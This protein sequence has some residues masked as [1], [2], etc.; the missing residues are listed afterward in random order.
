LRGGTSGK[1]PRFRHDSDVRY[2][3]YGSRVLRRPF[4]ARHDKNT[5]KDDTMHSGPA[6]GPGSLISENTRI[7]ELVSQDPLYAVYSAES[8]ASGEKVGITE[9]F[10]GDLVARAPGGDVLLRSLELQNLFNL[11]RDRFMAEARALS[12]LRH[13]G[14]LRFDGV[15]S[16]HGT[17]FALHAAEEGQSVTSLIKSSKQPLPQEAMDAIVKQLASALELMHSRNLIHANITPDTILLR[18]DPLLVRFGATRSFIAARM[19]K[20]NLAVTPG[21]SAPELHFSDEKARGPL[22]DIFSLAAVL[23]F[24]VTGR[25]PVNVIARGLGQTMPPAAGMPSHKFRP[26]FLEAIDRGLELEPERRPQRMKAFGEMLLGIPEKKA[27]ESTQPALQMPANLAE[28]AQVH[29][30]AKP[31]AVPPNGTSSPATKAAPKPSSSIPP[32]ETE[33]EEDD[34]DETHD[35]GSGWLG[36]GIRRLLTV[37]V[38]LALLISGG[39]W[40][41]EAQFKKQEQAARLDPRNDGNEP[42]GLDRPTSQGRLPAAGS[43]DHSPSTSP[44]EETSVPPAL[45]EPESRIVVVTKP[46]SEVTPA[47]AAAKRPSAIVQT[48]PETISPPETKRQQEVAPPIQ[49]FAVAMAICGLE[50][51]ASEVTSMIEG[52]DRLME[53][54]DQALRKRLAEGFLQS[55]P[56]KAEQLDKKKEAEE[57]RDTARERLEAG[58][59]APSS[60][61]SGQKQSNDL[62][63][64]TVSESQRERLEATAQKQKS[65]VIKDC[66]SC[67]ELVVVPEGSFFMGSPPSEEGRGHDEGPQ[68]RVTIEHSFAVGRFAIMVDEF[69]EF[70]NDTGYRTGEFC[71]AGNEYVARSAGSFEAPP[72]FAAGFV[73]AGRHPVVCVSWRDAKAFL[74]WLSNKTKRSYRLLTEAE[75]EYVTRAGTSTAYWWG[76]GITP[77]QALYD[78]ASNSTGHSKLSTAVSVASA[79]GTTR[80]DQYQPNPWGLFQVHGNVAEWVE[81][82]WEVATARASVS[83][84]AVVLPNCKDHVLRGG[85]WSY[86]K[87]A[88]RAAFREHAPADGRYNHVGF[89]VARDLD[90]QDHRP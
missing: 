39:L 13:P 62:R 47:E 50:A 4:K 49:P 44:S 31:S 22:C 60:G 9:Y 33:D 54:A 74:A 20:V 19:G 65:L 68:Q 83:P 87:T 58:L 2:K 88:L 12:A 86:P 76:D 80:V 38:V 17:A 79:G 18:P 7:L 70:V 71:A 14:L 78:A 81:D 52:A 23:Y 90:E 51:P 27:P 3:T 61:V 48:T 24:L 66:E 85:A 11:G 64:E 26:Q 5:S 73:Q 37:A 43:R 36:L 41:L 1:N 77:S 16:D 56:K 30:S 63:R 10:P 57:R 59:Q 40:M 67:P 82:C 84:A 75:R 6:L 15:V 28:S 29:P 53:S 55:C 34:L 45:T 72:G 46:G 89:R 21:Y 35:F 69:K 42:K 8:T 25:H 32:A